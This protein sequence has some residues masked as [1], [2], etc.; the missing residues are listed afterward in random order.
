MEAKILASFLC[1]LMATVH[2]CFYRGQSFK[3]FQN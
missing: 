3:F 2:E 1:Q